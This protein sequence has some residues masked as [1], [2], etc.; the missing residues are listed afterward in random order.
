MA[1]TKGTS[2][3]P[4]GRPRGVPGVSVADCFSLEDIKAAAKR[5]QNIASGANKQLQLKANELLLAYGLG[6]PTQAI[7]HSGSIDI[8]QTLLAIQKVVEVVKRFVPDEAT[9]GKIA[10]ALQEV[11]LN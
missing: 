9:R 8:R 7:E 1:F 4:N 2:G 6:K 5:V 11:E 10:E 3:N